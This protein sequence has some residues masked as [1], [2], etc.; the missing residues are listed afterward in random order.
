LKERPTLKLAIL[1]NKPD[2]FTKKVAEHFFYK[3]FDYALGLE[4][5]NRK[6]SIFGV[7]KI[8]EKL[9]T[10]K[11]GMLLIGD[12]QLDVLTAKNSEIKFV[13]ALWGYQKKN[14]LQKAGATVFIERPEQL[15]GILHIM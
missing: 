11:T 3:I 9:G 13:A 5:K 8:C 6:P 4:G 7:D 15:L 10:N 1:S 2:V 14:V 12:S